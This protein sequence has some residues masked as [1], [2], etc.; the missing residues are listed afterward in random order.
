[1]ITTEIKINADLEKVWKLWTSPAHIAN[2][3]SMDENWHTPKVKN[4]LRDGGKFLFRMETTDGSKGFDHEGK[5]DKVTPNERI[6]YTLLD[7][8]KV[9]NTFKQNG[10]ETL[11]TEIFD[12]ETET[13]VEEQ[14]MFCQAI[15]NNFKRYTENFRK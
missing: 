9:I 10:D 4:D 6:E 1:M 5:Y 2:W 15:L 12:P 7:G 11:I 14:K 3:N 8:R 13:P